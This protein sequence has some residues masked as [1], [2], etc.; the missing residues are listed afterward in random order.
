MKK[1]YAS[2]YITD[3]AITDENIELKDSSGFSYYIPKTCRQVVAEFEQWFTNVFIVGK[4]QT[5][6]VFEYETVDISECEVEMH[7]V[8]FVTKS[9]N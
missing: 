7:I 6:T 8:K 9:V 1:R 3:V 5:L 2:R 4:A